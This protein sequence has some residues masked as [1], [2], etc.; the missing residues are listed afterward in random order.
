MWRLPLLAHE[1]RHLRSAVADRVNCSHRHGD[2]VQAAPY[3]SEF[4]PP[5]TRWAHVDI[6]APAWNNEPPYGEVPHGATGFGVRT[7]LETL[8]ALGG[9]A[10]PQ[11]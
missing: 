3:L 4:L 10:E 8:R 9:A 11:P 2:T 5:G 6:A 1:R 7:I